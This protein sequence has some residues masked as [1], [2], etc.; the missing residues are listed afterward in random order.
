MNE[1]GMSKWLVYYKYRDMDGPMIEESEV[2]SLW[3]NEV[4]LKDI[5][6]KLAPKTNET[7]NIVI[8]NMVRLK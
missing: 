8:M 4:E 6:K 5:L 2:I 7:R 3:I 1:L